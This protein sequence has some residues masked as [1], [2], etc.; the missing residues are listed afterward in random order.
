MTEP[1]LK[2]GLIITQDGT[3]RKIT[4]I[5]KWTYTICE[6]NGEYMNNLTHRQTE[7]YYRE[8]TPEE[9]AKLL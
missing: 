8:V 5:R 4:E 2:C 9:K 3:I 1:K 7:R 6:L